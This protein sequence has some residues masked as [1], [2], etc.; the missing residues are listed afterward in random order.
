MHNGIYYKMSSTCYSKSEEGLKMTEYPL[1]DETIRAD[2]ILSVS[3]MERLDDGKIK[4]VFLS[5]ANPFVNVPRSIMEPFLSKSSKS[6]LDSIKK[7]YTKN[8]KTL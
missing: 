1:P 5:K 3:K 4:L 2:S 8:H 7:H 6:W